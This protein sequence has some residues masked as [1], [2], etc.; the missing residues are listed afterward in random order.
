ML[1]ELQDNAFCFP[2]T[3]TSFADTSAQSPTPDAIQHLLDRVRISIMQASSSSFT[4][5]SCAVF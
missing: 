5:V 1:L 3:V 2:V 4:N